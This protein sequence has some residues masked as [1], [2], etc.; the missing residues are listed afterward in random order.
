MEAGT[1]V[2]TA[3]RAAAR[4]RI[5]E[6]HI[7]AENTHD[8]EGIM[9]TFGGDARYDDEPWAEHHAG[10]NGVHAYYEAV[11]KAVPDL[12]IDV[13]R[14]HIADDAIV[15]EVVIAGTQLGTW[16]GLP[17]TGRRL[18]FP[19]SAVY[20]FTEDDRLAG[21]RIY[22][23]RATVLRQLGVFHEPEAPLGKLLAPLN[24]P[25]TFARALGRKLRRT[26]RRGG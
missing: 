22:Y 5:V 3:D 11:L 13:K 10:R 19:V 4:L 17:A 14:R 9:A 6:E 23:D 1:E 24:H 25:I 7:R 8:L 21:E 12:S 18:E 20:T 26:D 15:L 16:R 2:T